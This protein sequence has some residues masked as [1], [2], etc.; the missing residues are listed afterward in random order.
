[1]PIAFVRVEYVKRSA[2]KNACCIAAYNSRSTIEFEGTKWQ[3]PR[4]YNF[5][6]REPPV[7][8]EVLLPEGADPKFKSPEALWNHAEQQ[9]NRRNSQPSLNVVIALPDD[10]VVSTEDRIY[11]TRTFVQ[12]HFVKHGLAAQIDIHPPDKRL[13]GVHETRDHNWHAHVVVTTRRFKGKTLSSHKARDLMPVIRKGYVVSGPQWNKLWGQYQNAFFEEK[14]LSLRVDPEGVVPQKH[15]GPV[16]M[17]GRAFSLMEE[18]SLRISLNALEAE[19]PQK[20]LDK[21]TQT[22]NI[23]TQED[24]SRFLYKH[25]D[26]EKVHSVQETFWKQP[27]I[28]QL[29]DPSTQKPLGK[30]TTQEIVQEEKQIIRVADRLITQPAPKLLNPPDPSNLT[31]EQKQAYQNILQ[32]KK[33]S[34]LEG[35]AGTGKSYLLTALKQAYEAEGHTVRG[36]GPDSTTSQV[37]QEKGFS[38]AENIYR[39]LFSLQNGKRTIHKNEVW[40]LDEAGKLGS[41]PLL[42]LLKKAYKHNAQVI[43]SG[44]SA[45]MSSVERGVGFHYFS[46]KYGAHHLEN[47]QRQNEQTQREIAQKLAH[48]K[49]GSA[50]DEISKLGNL[51]WTPT[52]ENAIETLV[53]AWAQNNLS[54]P[55]EKTLILAHS[56]K[57]I[58]TS[59]ATSKT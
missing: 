24:I 54:N 53:K 58:R 48:G 57:E 8:H 33:L 52:K 2:G 40:I 6:N 23:F 42:E 56:N 10:E 55:N 16:R 30:F 45:Q 46:Q 22:Q 31:P 19:N 41:R 26:P 5:S 32:G 51:I 28:V 1:M 11:L 47:I 7:Y 21:I 15:L 17:R 25:V 43:L 20:V 18:N 49:M 27:Q 12:E 3:K 44:N 36:F 4:T 38:E 13:E 29:L 9:E 14:G 59:H 39:F 35:H 37:L 50:L 34:L